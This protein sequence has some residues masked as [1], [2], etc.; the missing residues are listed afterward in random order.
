MDNNYIPNRF[1]GSNIRSSVICSKH[2]YTDVCVE[3]CALGKLLQQYCAWIQSKL[4]IGYGAHF[5]LKSLSLPQKFP[6]WP[7]I[8][9]FIHFT[10]FI[11]ILVLCW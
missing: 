1:Y 9:F 7:R 5:F 11:Y 4:G 6:L 10:F 2:S 8:N 3:M